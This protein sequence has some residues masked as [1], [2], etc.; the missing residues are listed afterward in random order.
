MDRKYQYSAVIG[1][2]EQ[3]MA[4]FHNDANNDQHC[5]L[6]L[7]NPLDL[8]SLKNEFFIFGDYF[9]HEWDKLIVQIILPVHLRFSP[10]TLSPGSLP[11]P[12][13][14][15]NYCRVKDLSDTTYS[16]NVNFK[17]RAC[18][19]LLYGVSAPPV[20]CLEYYNRSIGFYYRENI[21]NVT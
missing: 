6:N 7:S 10:Q 13:V 19:F 4:N 14:D 1:L 2:A 9:L 15:L 18:L 5:K 11:D 3:L 16:S 17:I 21:I 20:G 8:N 12:P